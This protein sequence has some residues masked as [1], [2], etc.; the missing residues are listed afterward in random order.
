MPIKAKVVCFTLASTLFLV[1]F[2]VDSP[3]SEIL[4]LERS[5]L[6][7]HIAVARK[8]LITT[9]KA[10]ANARLALQEAEDQVACCM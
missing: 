6:D 10:E 2:F 8:E 9:E 5:S 3:R 1:S 4:A 7:P